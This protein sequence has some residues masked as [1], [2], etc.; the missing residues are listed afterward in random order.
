MYGNGVV[1]LKTRRGHKVKS[2]AISRSAVIEAFGTALHGLGLPSKVTDPIVALLALV[3]RKVLEET[4]RRKMERKAAKG[5][6]GGG[7]KMGE[8]GQEGGEPPPPTPAPSTP[9][10]KHQPLNNKP[11]AVHDKRSAPIPNPSPLHPK[12]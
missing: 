1:Y 7:V 4:K 12:H 3:R 10:T 2:F 6:A 8:K 9:N 11:S 5:G